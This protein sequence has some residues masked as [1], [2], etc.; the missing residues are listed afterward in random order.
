MKNG[1]KIF[2][3]IMFLLGGVAVLVGSMGYLQG[4]GFWTILFSIVLIGILMDGVMNKR[5]GG[6][7]F[8]LAFLGILNSKW[9]GIEHLVPWPILGAA[10]F[11]TIGLNILFPRGNFL[12]KWSTYN[13]GFGHWHNRNK[14][15]VHGID[16]IHLGHMGKNQEIVGDDGSE[17]VKCEVSFGS[18]IKYI[19]SRQLSNAYFEC[20]FG[21]LA[22]YLDNAGL[23]DQQAS[24]IVDSAFGGIEL[25]VPKEWKVILDV[26]GAF[27]GTSE[28]GHCDPMGENV[29]YVR[30]EVA[31]GGL[32]I[33]YI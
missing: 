6:I 25:Y 26:S 20:A 28:D 23:K 13:K 5:W 10:L 29:L 31:F 24:I 2:W 30:G 8:P 17:T 15:Y 9:L 27:G 11:G 16:E 7:L 18:E 4:I 21:S 32:E 12:W 3:G 1:K 14:S 33:H 19:N 22:V